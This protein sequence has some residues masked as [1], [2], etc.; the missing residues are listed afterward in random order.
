MIIH[1]CKLLHISERRT[2]QV[3]GQARATQ[4]RI[5]GTNGE[6]HRLT[7][8]IIELATKYSRYGYRGIAALLRSESWKVN[9]KR[10]ERI[11]RREG[12]KVPKKQPRRGRLWLNDGSRVRLRPEYKDHVLEPVQLVQPMGRIRA[13]YESLSAHLFPTERH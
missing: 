8:H 9:H 11:W 10:V 12:L 5:P 1:V 3:L 6:E 13:Y 2:C 7:A 4:R